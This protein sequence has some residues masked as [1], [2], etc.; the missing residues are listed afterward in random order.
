MMYHPNQAENERRLECGLSCMQIIPIS[1]N[2]L[3]SKMRTNP[4]SMVQMFENIITTIY[5][6]TNVVF[7]EET[8]VNAQIHFHQFE[9]GIEP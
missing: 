6:K 4:T 3:S 5:G 9:S 8:T 1:G 2:I 7:V